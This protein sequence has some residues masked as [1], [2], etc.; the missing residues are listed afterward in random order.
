MMQL[1]LLSL[2]VLLRVDKKTEESVKSKVNEKVN[3]MKDSDLGKELTKD[4]NTIIANLI[5]AKR[6]GNVELK[7]QFRKFKKEHGGKSSLEI[8]QSVKEVFNDLVQ[9]KDTDSVTEVPGTEIN[10]N[11][12]C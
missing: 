4:F 8:Y 5:V 11:K 1:M 2:I 10:L 6:K 9:G 7:K 3:N 12:D